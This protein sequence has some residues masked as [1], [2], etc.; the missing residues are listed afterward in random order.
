MLSLL[1]LAFI[2]YHATIPEN[3][4]KVASDN[5][6]VINAASR[7]WSYYGRYGYVLVNPQATTFLQKRG[8]PMV[9]AC[10]I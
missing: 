10:E 4:R 6:P 2:Y 8:R 7:S 9:S 5:L 3:A 1:P